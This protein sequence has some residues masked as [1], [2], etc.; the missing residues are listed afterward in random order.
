MTSHVINSHILDILVTDIPILYVGKCV[1]SYMV[2]ILHVKYYSS[3]EKCGL[4]SELMS[5]S[6]TAAL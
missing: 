1:L 4:W 2:S 5:R 3:Y 6:Y